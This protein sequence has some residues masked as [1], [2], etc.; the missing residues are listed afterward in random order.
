M[1]SKRSTA[2][3]AVLLAV[4]M[5][6]TC[7]LSGCNGFFGARVDTVGTDPY[8]TPNIRGVWSAG[9]INDEIGS[10]FDDVIA[11][12]KIANSNEANELVGKMRYS[13]E[14]VGGKNVLR[15][16]I[17]GAEGQKL[18]LPDIVLNAKECAAA[19]SVPECVA[20]YEI[21]KNAMELAAYGVKV[22][23]YNMDS[24]LT[25]AQMADVLI[26]WY[27]EKA[28]KAVDYSAVDSAVPEE[29]SKKVLALIPDYEYTEE[30]IYNSDATTT[31]LVDTL[32]PL[33]S[34]LNYQVYGVYSGNAKLIDFVKYAELFLRMYAPEGIDYNF[35]TEGENS[36]EAVSGT[37]AGDV[38][39]STDWD[40]TVSDTNLYNAVDSVMIQSEESLTRLS[41]AKNMLLILKAGYNAEVKA[42]GTVS[43]C[44][45][46]SAAI[47]TENSIMPSFP[48]D[49]SLFTPDY[50][51]RANELPELSANFTEYCYNTWNSKDG[52]HYY[53][54]LTMREMCSAIASLE[55]FYDNYSYYVLEEV[56]ENINNSVSDDWY[57]TSRETGE[58]AEK[59]V[60]VAGVAMALRW[61]GKT[62]HTVES[63][64]NEYLSEVDIE[65][66]KVRE[67]DVLKAKGV[68]A[69]RIEKFTMESVLNELRNGNIVM[70]RYNSTGA[71]GVQ[72]M[73][74]YGF[75]KNGN[76]IRFIYND[77]NPKTDKLTYA[78][79]SVPGK[80]EKIES[81][82]ALWLVNKAGGDYTVVY[83]AG[84]EPAPVS[85]TDQQ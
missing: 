68:T 18:M 61:S 16:W 14:S 25:A 33:M 28:G 10:Y 24:A 35:E 36:T 6:M 13:V 77:P 39:L 21:L 63:L 51:V 22:D 47:M 82:L 74:I 31:M 50:E 2:A 60:S 44:T 20:D 34:E 54:Y 32:A 85:E 57:A 78:N 30:L 29:A 12:L 45:D 66:G 71:G 17:E 26:A 53:D 80:G 55:S 62:E 42:K 48:V 41:L 52:Y 70:A 38:K 49:S 84:N 64:R 59:N 67:I 73:I 75:E 40:R 9:R 58:Y 8:Q 3:V 69:Q 79:G 76:S 4:V 46:E 19:E 23:L 11:S 83:K 56:P 43:D 7:L 15:S 5:S 81:E 27:E 65:W 1:R 72:Y 37:D